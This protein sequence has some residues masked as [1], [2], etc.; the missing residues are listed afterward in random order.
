MWMRSLFVDNESSEYML[1]HDMDVYIYI[2]ILATASFSEWV[3]D[4]FH[5]SVYRQRPAFTRL[6]NSG[7]NIRNFFG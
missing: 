2:Y 5:A 7:P 4:C 3:D 6:P 1:H